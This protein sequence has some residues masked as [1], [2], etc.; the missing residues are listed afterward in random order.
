[1]FSEVARIQNPELESDIAGWQWRHLVPAKG[2]NGTT[3]SAG[4]DST[5]NMALLLD[6]FSGDPLDHVPVLDTLLVDTWKMPV[7]ATPR[8]PTQ[9]CVDSGTSKRRESLLSKSASETGGLNR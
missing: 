2:P 8:A 7:I 6:A 3:A 1:M 9:E 5:Q 4:V